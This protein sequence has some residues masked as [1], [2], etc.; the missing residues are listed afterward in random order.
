MPHTFALVEHTHVHIHT[1]IPIDRGPQV[2]YIYIYRYRYLRVFI[3]SFIHT[4]IHTNIQTYIHTCAHIFIYTQMHTHRH[5]H[6]H[7]PVIF[8]QRVRRDYRSG[9]NRSRTPLFD[10]EISKSSRRHERTHRAVVLR[11]RI[12]VAYVLMSCTFVHCDMLLK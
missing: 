6:T 8:T 5:T 1:Y 10:T 3:H 4:Y 12:C 9:N 2:P 7:I 11:M